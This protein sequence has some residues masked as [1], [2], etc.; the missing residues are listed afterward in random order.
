MSSPAWYISSFAVQNF[1]CLKDVS[2]ELTPLHAFIGP[3]DSGKSTLLRA[4]RMALRLTTQPFDRE[5]K[6]S[7]ILPFEPGP[8]VM[9]TSVLLGLDFGRSRLSH[10]VTCVGDGN[11]FVESGGPQNR[12]SPA[13]RPLV[14]TSTPAT[15]TRGRWCA[16]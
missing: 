13:P 16:A 12:Q 11:Q 8:V 2:A 1:A 14:A 3:N 5:S 9:G 15:V 6:T 4:L 10:R 7:A